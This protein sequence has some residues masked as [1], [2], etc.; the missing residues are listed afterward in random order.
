[1]TSTLHLKEHV[2]QAANELIAAFAGNDTEA[3]FAAFSEDATFL[4][5]TLPA[6]LLSRAAYQEVWKGWQAD[7]FAV[8]D[9][10]SSNAHISLQ[11]DV[12]IFMHDV[13][14]R[15]RFGSEENQFHERETIV[16]RHDGGRWLACHE[17]LSTQPE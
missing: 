13:A 17:H 12:A 14:T 11:G 7:G 9:C 16:F 3:Y 2:Q 4:F 10:Q 5:Y 1:M 15:V 6:P 8:L